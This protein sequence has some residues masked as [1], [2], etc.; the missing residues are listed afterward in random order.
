MNEYID[1][2]CPKCQSSNITAFLNM[3]MASDH[4]YIDI[5]VTCQECK[6]ELRFTYDL[7]IVEEEKF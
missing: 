2:I 6:T 4:S 3:F 5:P 7:T 1:P